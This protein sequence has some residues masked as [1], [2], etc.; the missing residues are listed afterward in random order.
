MAD[1]TRTPVSIALFVVAAV[2]FGIAAL[3]QADQLSQVL[4]GLAAAA[5]AVA[6]VIEW[7]RQA[8][9]RG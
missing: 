2:C 5:M 3:L 4:F 6:A 1:R 8:R 9:R 7:R